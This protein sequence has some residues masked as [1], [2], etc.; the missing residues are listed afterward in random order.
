VR[1]AT[2]DP[3]ERRVFYVAVTRAREELTLSYCTFRR[4]GRTQPS[5]FLADIGRGLL[6]RAKLGS[7]EP[8]PPA[9]R[10]PAK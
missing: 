8:S 3:E 5:P 7:D 1:S 6:R 10:K 9:K 4:D 2:T